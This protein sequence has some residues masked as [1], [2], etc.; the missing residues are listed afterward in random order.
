M[1][2]CIFKGKRGA[3]FFTLDTLIAGLIIVVTL[4]LVLSIYTSRPVV[5]DTYHDLSNYMNFLTSTTMRA[6]RDNYDTPYQNPNE[7]DLDLYIYQ[8]VYKLYL[9]NNL[10]EARSLV[11]NLSTIIIPAHMGFRYDVADVNVFSMNTQRIN[12]ATTSV[13]NRLLTF[14][15]NDTGGVHITT[16]NITV[17]S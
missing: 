14:V 15:V 9:E 7:Q 10:S 11:G 8:K 1:V 17:W 5:E 6:V 13:T 16:T 3:I 4:I 12:V 2:S